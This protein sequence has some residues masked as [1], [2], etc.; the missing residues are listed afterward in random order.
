MEQKLI[1]KH[2]SVIPME[3]RHTIDNVL[4]NYDFNVLLV[5]RVRSAYK[6]HTDSGN[7]CL[8]KVSRG[9]RKSKKSFYISKHLKDNGFSNVAD[10]YPTKKNKLFVKINDTVYYLT[11]WIEGREADFKIPYE[12]LKCAEMLAE[13]HNH[14]KGFKKTKSIRIRSYYDKWTKI[15]ERSI[16]EIHSFIIKIDKLDIKTEFDYIYKENID[17]YVQEAKQAIEILK[18]SNCSLL[19]KHQKNQRYVCHDSYYYQNILI[20]K[21]DKMYIVDLESCCYNLP[22]SDLGKFIRRVLSKSKYKWD[23]RLWQN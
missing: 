18:H 3:E 1:R 13:F 14:A 17:Y 11:Y 21:T 6:I 22:M 15:F 16:K 19:R 7:F 12:V 9:Y 8:K 20:D 5:E 2:D 4:K 23:F 10:Y